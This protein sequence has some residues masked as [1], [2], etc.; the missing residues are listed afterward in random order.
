MKNPVFNFLSSIRLTLFL[1]AA[2]LLL[3]FFGTLDQVHYGI[4]HTQQKYFEHAFVVWEYPAQWA[5][6]EALS[7]LH[8]PMPG[9]YLLGPLLVVNLVCAHFHY[10]RPSWKK[11][12]ITLIHAGIVLLL[13]G[14]LW[15]QLRQVEYF[16]WLEEGQEQNFVEAFHY[17]EF[18][19]IDKSG[20]ETEQVFSWD[21]RALRQEGRVLGNPELPFEAEVLWYARNAAI[22]PRPPQAGNRF[23]E[24]PFNRG[25]GEERDLVALMK[26]PT[27][28][29]GE[30]NATSAIVR[31]R[32]KESGEPVG[33]WLL[34]NL[35]RQS[36]PMQQYFPPQT[37][38][39]DGREWEIA[40]RFKRKYLP[41]EI[42]LLDFKHDQYPGTTIAY[43]FSSEVKILKPEEAT[44]RT[45]LIYMNHPLR[46]A[47][48]TFYQA[49]FA[50]N[51]TK[52]MFQV[53]RNPARWVPYVACAIVSLGLVLQFGISL[54][55]HALRRPRAS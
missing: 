23:P 12:G 46:Y 36:L 13:L 48:L 16:L 54:Y 31:L 15:T 51:N 42:Q 19:L 33:T 43:N 21:A 44:G 39:H 4:Y 25:I 37:F 32:D 18:V 26:K 41:A 52:S 53:V 49:S 2:S 20:E 7:W 50:D 24:M 11:V 34:S 28:A 45:T 3:V 55:V 5:F 6:G 29:E 40:L 17:D 38:E 47:G 30:R 14:Q 9:G 22:F 35:F 27:Y 10:F 1:L 8:L